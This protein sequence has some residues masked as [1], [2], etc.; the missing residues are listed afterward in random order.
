M[1]YLSATSYLWLHTHLFLAQVL[2]VLRRVRVQRAVMPW[3]PSPPY[4]QRIW[5]LN[6]CFGRRGASRPAGTP[7]GP[8]N[9]K[10]N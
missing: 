1:Y 6:I 5:D 9:I 2:R 7:K 8:G 4:A 3:I 10:K